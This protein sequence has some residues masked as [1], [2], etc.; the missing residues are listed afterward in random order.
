MV[1]CLVLCSS[2][3][4]QMNEFKNYESL[5]AYDR[6]VSGW[7]RKVEA[8]NIYSN[9]DNNKVLKFVVVRSRVNHSQRLS[10]SPVSS[11]I[12]CG[13]NGEVISCHCTCMAGLGE[14]C[15]HVASTMFFIEATNRL[16]EKNTVTQEPASW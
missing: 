13:K 14:T 7:V 5:D 2:P 4:Y 1:N 15:S 8:V 3:F 9:S 10:E 11:W 12:I 6:F 16:N